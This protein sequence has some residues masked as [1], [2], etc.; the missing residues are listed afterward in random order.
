MSVEPV[1]LYQVILEEVP[2]LEYDLSVLIIVNTGPFFLF[3]S[4]RQILYFNCHG[5][6]EILIIVISQEGKT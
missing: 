6:V 4:A 5:L 3:M 1:Y 2:V